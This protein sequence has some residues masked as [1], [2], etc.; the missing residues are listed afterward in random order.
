MVND[1]MLALGDY[2]FSVGTAAYQTHIRSTEYRWIAVDRQARAPALQFAGPGKDEITLPGVIFPAQWGG[3]QQVNKMREMAGKGQPLLL[4]DGLGYVWDNWCITRIQ[5][6]QTPG[7]RGGAAKKQTFE[8]SIVF[9]GA[10][11]EI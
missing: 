8:V 6:E 5:E 7:F 9:Y 4:V 3:L 10:D 2:R 11:N 1:V